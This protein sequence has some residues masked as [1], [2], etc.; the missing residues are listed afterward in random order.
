VVDEAVVP[1]DI[2]ALTVMIDHDLV[3][4]APAARFLNDFV[5]RLK[6]GEGIER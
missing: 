3:D 4:G 1:R 5:T 2:L 6:K